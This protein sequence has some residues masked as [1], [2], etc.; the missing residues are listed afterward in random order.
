MVIVG[1][2]PGLMGG[3]NAFVVLIVLYLVGSITAPN[4][5][6]VSPGSGMVIAQARRCFSKRRMWTGVGLS[7]SLLML[8]AP[9][10]VGKF[11]AAS[12]DGVL[13]L[14]VC[15]VSKSNNC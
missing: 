8:I 7:F 15:I 2:C 11:A 12:C 3:V 4:N 6:N 10:G 5:P 1:G 9:F 13:V 14:V